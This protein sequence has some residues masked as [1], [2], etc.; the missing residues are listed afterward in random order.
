MVDSH[1][2]FAAKEMGD[3]FFYQF[4]SQYAEIHAGMF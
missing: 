1:H 2:I 4:E 3:A